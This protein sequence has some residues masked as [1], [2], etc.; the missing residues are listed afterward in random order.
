MPSATSGH[1]SLSHAR[2]H[3]GE[4]REAREAERRAAPAHV[5][6]PVRNGA[7]ADAH[8]ASRVRVGEQAAGER[9]HV[10]SRRDG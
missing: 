6:S 8:T 7:G 1:G 2:D 9:A 5:T 10:T 3:A 4:R